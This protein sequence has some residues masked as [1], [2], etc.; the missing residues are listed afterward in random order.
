MDESWIVISEAKESG[1]Q[2]SGDQA[3]DPQAKLCAK[4]GQLWGSYFDPRLTLTDVA[5][6]TCLRHLCFSQLWYGR[7]ESLKD[8]S[9][10][11][12]FSAVSYRGIQTR[13][14]NQSRL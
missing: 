9:L 13:S 5:D 2:T 6:V 3:S 4:L 12:P 7:L 11:A 10:Y 14:E 8:S 1:L